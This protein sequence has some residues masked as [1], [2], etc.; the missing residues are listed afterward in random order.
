MLPALGRTERDV[1]DAGDQ[2]VTVEDSMSQ[3]HL[4]RGRLEP[5]SRRLLSEPAI[6][7]RL[8]RATL[9]GSAAIPWQD[10]EADYG[11]IRERIS[12]VVPGFED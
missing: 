2:F 11:T 12:R 9:D 7:A 8:A 3:V 1:Q 4:T 10:F 5:A 6:V